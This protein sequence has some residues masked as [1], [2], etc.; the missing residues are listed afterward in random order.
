MHYEVI[1]RSARDVAVQHSP[2]S[3]GFRGMRSGRGN[4]LS[5]SSAGDRPANSAI[6]ALK[7]TDPLRAGDSSMPHRRPQ[8]STFCGLTQCRSHNGDRR[9]TVRPQD[10]MSSVWRAANRRWK[11]TGAVATRGSWRLSRRCAV[12]GRSYDALTPA[13]RRGPLP[14]TTTPGPGLSPAPGAP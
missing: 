9:T 8:R 13:A 6:V 14:S 12:R 10:R 5:S 2:A 7:N 3:R 11:H 1:T 4:N